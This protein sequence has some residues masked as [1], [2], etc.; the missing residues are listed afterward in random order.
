MS[1]DRPFVDRPFVDRP[2]VDRAAAALIAERQAADWGLGRPRVLRHGMNSL[3]VV[4]GVVL[5]V[6]LATAPAATAHA[7]V[8]WLLDADVPTIVPV[9]GLVADVDSYAVTGWRLVRETRQAVDWRAVGRAVRLVHSLDPNRVPS[10]FPVPSPTVFA[11]WRFDDLLADVAE[12]IDPAAL[13]GLRAAVERHR[14]WEDRV[15]AGSVLC[16]GDVHPGNVLTSGGGPLLV[17]WD[18]MCR[19]NPAWDHGM[20]TTV[21]ERWGGDAGAYQRFVDGYGRALDDESLAQALGELRNVAA[22]L[23]RV[24]AARHDESARV[25]AEH[26]LRF[27]RGES[28]AAWHAQ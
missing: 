22:T 21:A 5:R 4:D 13:D 7:L 24:R 17:D 11:W 3:F 8:R 15:A 28:D 14:G 19:A 23:M 6:G 1:V 12:E 20:L 25:E 18:L 16:H 2:V 26:R 10:G 9:D 27:W